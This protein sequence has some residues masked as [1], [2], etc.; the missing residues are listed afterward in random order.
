MERLVGLRREPAP[1]PILAAE[2]D[3]LQ[4]LTCH[5][6]TPSGRSVSCRDGSYVAFCRETR[7]PKRDELTQRS[8]SSPRRREGTQPSRLP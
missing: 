8:S 4:S 1:S 2:D 6:C 7:E 5:A 3:D